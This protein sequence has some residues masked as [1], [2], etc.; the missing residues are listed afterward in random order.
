MQ[1]KITLHK[2]CGSRIF[3][4]ISNLFIV[5]SNFFVL[6]KSSHFKFCKNLKTAVDFVKFLKWIQSRYKSLNFDCPKGFKKYVKKV[7]YNMLWCT[8]P[9]QILPMNVKTLVL[10]RWF[11][12]R[13]HHPLRLRQESII[14][15]EF[16]RKL[17]ENE[18]NWT[19]TRPIAS[20][21]CLLR[22]VRFNEPPMWLFNPL[23]YMLFEKSHSCFKEKKVFC[24]IWKM[25]KKIRQRKMRKWR[26]Q[27]ALLCENCWGHIIISIWCSAFSD[28]I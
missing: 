23:Y 11:S 3:V 6:K 5:F 8:F 24:T 19:L 16:C 17:H 27:E 26:K 28:I 2:Q 15:Q 4:L 12:N 18:R 25:S 1:T 7:K 14:W 21:N 13:G 10:S 9:G 22:K 20:L